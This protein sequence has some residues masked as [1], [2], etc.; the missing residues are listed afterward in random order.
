M[1]L[2]RRERPRRQSARREPST[3]QN[4]ISWSPGL[5]EKK[6]AAWKAITSLP[7]ALESAHAILTVILQD[8]ALQG[9]DTSSYLSLRQSYA[10]AV[11]RLVNGLVDPLQLGAYARSINSIATQ[12]GL[13]AWLVELRHAAT[14]EDLPSIE[15]L[16]EAARQA[17]AWLLQN[18]FL[19]TLN[20]TTPNPSQLERPSLRPLS[21]LLKQYKAFAKATARDASLTVKY[22][23]DMARVLRDVER[24][25]AEA[26]VA[27]P[28]G[29]TAWDDI[30]GEEGDEVDAREGW[31]LERLAEALLERGALVPVSKK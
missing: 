3:C 6:L 7:H 9:Q 19:P 25:V 27:A 20:P 1:G 23:H 13:P 11:I 31:A 26:K 4:V 30:D 29:A 21:P 17:L 18:Y 16:R 22:K 28:V 5:T 10:T 24:W 8:S 15:V 2:F 14:H 12:L